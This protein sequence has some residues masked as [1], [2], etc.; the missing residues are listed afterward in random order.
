VD[1]VAGSRELLEH[2]EAKR[3]SLIVNLFLAPVRAGVRVPEQIVEHVEGE[4]LERWGAAHRWRNAERI[5]TFRDDLRTLR[6]HAEEALGLARWA[7]VYEGL[8][9]AERQKLKDQRSREGIRAWM[10]TQPPT[11]K[12]LDYLAALGYRGE[13]TSRGHASDL[14]DGLTRR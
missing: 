1:A 5:R 10:G 6:E 11:Q 13:V 2:F 12:Q 3:R 14:I 8:P 7:I 9:P 4:L